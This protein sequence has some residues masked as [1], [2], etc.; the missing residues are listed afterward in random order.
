MEISPGVGY[1][2]RAAPTLLLPP[3]IVYGALQH[4]STF[5]TFALTKALWLRFILLLVAD[6]FALYLLDQ[7]TELSHWRQARRLGAQVLPQ[8]RGR[9]YVPL[10]IDIL[11]D[12]V[13]AIPGEYVADKVGDIF[14]TDGKTVVFRAAVNVEV[15]HFATIPSSIALLTL[16]VVMTIEPRYVKRILATNFENF[17]KG[18]NPFGAATR[19]VFGVGIFNSDGDLWKFH[20]TLTRPFF[21]RDRI[22]DF[23]IFDKHANEIIDIMRESFR[24]DTPLDIQDVFGRFTLDSAT[25][26]LFGDCVNS[27]REP[28]LLP[29]GQEPHNATSKGH[30]TSAFVKAFSRAQEII[31][32][33]V[34]TGRLWPLREIKKDATAD[35]VKQFRRYFEPILDKALQR[36]EELLQKKGPSISEV[37]EVEEGMS[38]LD[39][40]LLQTDDRALIRDSLVSMLI[41]GRDTTT[42]LITFTTYA[43]SQH[44]EILAA[45]REEIL[46][47]IGPSAAPTYEKIRDLKYL[48]AVLNETLRLFPPVPMNIRESVKADIWEAADGTRYFIP[49]NT[50]TGYAVIHM[51]RDKEL[52]GPDALDFDP[53]RWIDSR[54]ARL[55]ANP[56]MFLPFN[57]GPRICVGQ[58]F[59]Y[60]E[61]SFLLVRLLQTFSAITLRPDAQPTGTLPNPLGEWDLT[62]GRNSIE[63]IW[64]RSHSTLYAHGGL[65]GTMQEA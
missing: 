18:E 27:I 41:A 63:K 17:P 14:R 31:S 33:R 43:L 25:E 3:L 28:M 7:W 13:K 62:R 26:F 30:G 29:G 24:S 59:A 53:M 48:R 22:S 9:W 39:Y 46:R 15:H 45:A 35:P 34:R 5:P 40:L 11:I 8:V 42:C 32:I 54:L 1:L 19:S 37:R 65:W 50:P 44:P 61:A 47:V 55:T 10:K 52:W 2:F 57:A 6:P 58:Q 38:F 49:A 20:R 60:N 64:P 4:L 56:M 23:E 36:R 16:F 51:H 21:T 12:F